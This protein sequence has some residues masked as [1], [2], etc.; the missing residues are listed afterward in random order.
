MLRLGHFTIQSIKNDN[1]FFTRLRWNSNWF[2]D[3]R[4][5]IQNEISPNNQFVHFNVWKTRMKSTSKT[6]IRRKKFVIKSV[7]L[8]TSFSIS[9]DRGNVW[10]FRI[11]E[12]SRQ[13]I[14]YSL[15]SM[16]WCAIARHGWLG[17]RAQSRNL[18]GRCFKWYVK[19]MEG[20]SNVE[21]TLA[22]RRVLLELLDKKQFFYLS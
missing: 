13:W 3:L 8:E 6:V 5:P 18:G 15:V 17:R 7:C 9:I 12:R 19:R 22:Q 11:A 21:L 4:V 20:D 10:C 16:K 14:T 1:I 2:G